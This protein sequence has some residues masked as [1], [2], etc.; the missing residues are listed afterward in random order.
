MKFTLT[1][2]T[3]DVVSQVV[4]YVIEQYDPEP[5][6]GEWQEEEDNPYL[7]Q[8]VQEGLE[9][10]LKKWLEYGEILRVEFDTEAGTATVLEVK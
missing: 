1:F 10:K 6:D 9:E 8:E 2:K 3:P 5:G 7:R 4:D